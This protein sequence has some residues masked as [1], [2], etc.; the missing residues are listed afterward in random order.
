LGALT[1]K[2]L[3]M[4]LSIYGPQPHDTAAL[5]ALIAAIPEGTEFALI[6]AP[7]RRE[8]YLKACQ[9]PGWLEYV[10]ECDG[11]VWVHLHQQTSTSEYIL[12][13]QT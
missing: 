11:K 6:Q 9:R 10:A 12:K 8:P 3:D 4:K 2:E 13:V 7:P 5:A 1:L